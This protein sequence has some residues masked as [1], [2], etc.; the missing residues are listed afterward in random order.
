MRSWWVNHKQTVKEELSG[1]YI[2]SPMANRNGSKNQTYINLTRTRPLD[3]VV[4]YANGRIGAVGVMNGNCAQVERP[5]SFGEV[6]KRWDLQGWMVTV[7]WVRLQNSVV[8]R[9]HMDAIGS[10]LPQKYSP[11][12][13]NGSG[14]QGCYLAEIS[15]E[16][17]KVLIR[18]CG[19]HNSSLSSGLLDAASIVEENDESERIGRDDALSPTVKQQLVQARIGQ[20]VFRT[21]LENIEICCRVTA[22]SDS[23]FLTASHIKPWRDSTDQEKLDGNNGL[24]LAP[25]VDRLFDRGWISFTDEGELLVADADVESV[26][27]QWS[28]ASNTNVGAFNGNQRVFLAYHRAY[29]YKGEHP[30]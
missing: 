2:W 5:M 4:S 30:G 17:G 19:L 18:I 20:G 10:L 9:D 13:E 16:L 25:H 27:M 23:R 12:R 21:N 7:D 28:L 14:N 1:G 6:G 8:P 24:L 22:V 26:L 15:N 11:I 3:Q 29:V